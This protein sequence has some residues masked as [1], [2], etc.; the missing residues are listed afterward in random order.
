MCRHI[1]HIYTDKGIRRTSVTV[2]SLLCVLFGLFKLAFFHDLLALDHTA[3]A[4]RAAFFVFFPGSTT[5]RAVFIVFYQCACDL[6]SVGL[7][8]PKTY[9]TGETADDQKHDNEYSRKD[10]DHHKQ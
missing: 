3:S 2:S 9:T 6:L 4:V 1:N 7:I 5:V 10:T 8:G